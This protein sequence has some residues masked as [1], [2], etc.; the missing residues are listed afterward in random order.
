MDPAAP[1]ASNGISR[2]F[3]VIFAQLFSWNIYIGAL[4]NDKAGNSGQGLDKV[5]QSHLVLGHG[6]P[7]QQKMEQ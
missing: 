7:V 5:N 1:G 6:K 4:F 3:Q 2:F